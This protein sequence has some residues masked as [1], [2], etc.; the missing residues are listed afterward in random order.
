MQIEDK[1]AH[2]SQNPIKTLLSAR[3]AHPSQFPNSIYVFIVATIITSKPRNLYTFNETRLYIPWLQQCET[4]VWFVR[5]ARFCEKMKQQH[6]EN[7][8]TTTVSKDVAE[9][10][11]VYSIRWFVLAL[12]VMYSASNS[13]QWI[14][15]S[16]IADVVT[17][18]YGVEYTA[19]NWMSQIYMV[20]YIPF[21][22]PASYLLDKLVSTIYSKCWARNVEHSISWWNRRI[23]DSKLVQINWHLTNKREGF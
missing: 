18:Y 8:T 6:P 2:F 16:I 23:T 5:S 7:G 12:F 4:L 11:Q 1:F 14:Q 22:F 15:F 9:K 19:V 10:C 13:M 21:I 20:L 3:S 17:E